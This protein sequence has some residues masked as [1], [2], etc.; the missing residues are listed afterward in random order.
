MQTNWCVILTSILLGVDSFTVQN[1]SILSKNYEK[2][3]IDNTQTS[4]R[5]INKIALC[6]SLTATTMTH[7]AKQENKNENI[8]T[9]ASRSASTNHLG[10]TI[11]QTKLVSSLNPEIYGPT[12]LIRFKELLAYKN[13]HASCAVPKRYKDNP[14]LGMFCFIRS[15]FVELFLCLFVCTHSVMYFFVRKIENKGNWVNKTRQMYR[16]YN[17]G[18]PSSMTPERIKI[19]NDV[20]FIWSGSFDMNHDVAN[21][22]EHGDSIISNTKFTM[23]D[24]L[25]MNRYSKLKEYWMEGG[26]C[27]SNLRSSPYQKLSSWAM[28]QRREYHNLKRGEKSTMNPRRIELLE[29]IGF[30]WS[31]R[32]TKWNARVKELIEYKKL[33]GDCL[34]R[35]GR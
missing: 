27:Y 23:Q 8:Q 25:W 5:T 22:F 10:L 18:K 13:K 12:F 4:G 6:S 20:A 29:K 14:T 34:V 35:R 26:N 31:P 33:H 1:K 32:E 19:L 15:N 24:Q 16:K 9:N 7:P 28:R 3:N 2:R 17:E 30:D 11:E 21:K